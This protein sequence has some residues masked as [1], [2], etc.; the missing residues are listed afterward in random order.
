M[1]SN[2]GRTESCGKTAASVT[3]LR[4]LI[5]PRHQPERARQDVDDA[6][7]DQNVQREQRAIVTPFFPRWVLRENEAHASRAH[8][9]KNLARAQII[10]H[11]AHVVAPDLSVSCGHDVTSSDGA[12]AA[13]K[14]LM[15]FSLQKNE[16][17]KQR[18]VSGTK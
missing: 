15:P 5:Q 4:H 16:H 1:S 18:C 2:E 7:A 11:L 3:H 9:Q 17:K 8:R 12:S 13:R 14:T 6:H 10:G